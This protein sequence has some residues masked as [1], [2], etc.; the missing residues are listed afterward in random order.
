M[1]FDQFVPP[2]PVPTPVA[3]TVFVPIPVPV[4]VLDPEPVNRFPLP[5][6]HETF[7]ESVVA[8]EGRALAR[9]GNGTTDPGGFVVWEDTAALLAVVVAVVAVAVVLVVMRVTF[10]VE[11]WL[12]GSPVKVLGTVDDCSDSITDVTATP[13]CPHI[14]QKLPSEMK[15]DGGIDCVQLTLR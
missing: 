8:T 14:S 12:A 4:S 5:P 1:L 2:V 11:S 6:E 7:P 15:P 9:G 3:V 13:F 10:G